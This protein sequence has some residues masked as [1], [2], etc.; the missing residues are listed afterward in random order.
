MATGKFKITYE[1]H[2]WLTQH[3]HWAVLHQEI[4]FTLNPKGKPV[5]EAKRLGLCL[6]VIA[7]SHWHYKLIL[8]IICMSNVLKSLNVGS[9]KTI[10]KVNIGLTFLSILPPFLLWFN[11]E[12]RESKCPQLR[13]MQMD[14]SWNMIFFLMTSKNQLGFAIYSLGIS[15]PWD[16]AILFNLLLV[17]NYLLPC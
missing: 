11:A 1:T 2:L 6:G 7:T 4:L 15:S 9:F 17:G 16:L 12:I 13:P 3:F 5:T 8:F 14:F 10:L